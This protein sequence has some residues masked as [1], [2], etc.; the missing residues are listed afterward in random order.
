MITLPDYLQGRDVAPEYCQEYNAGVESNAVDLLMRVNGLMAEFGESRKVNSGWRPPS[1]N[2]TVLGAAK[3][4]RHM[5]GEAIDLD[6][7]YGDLDEWLMS[8]N[9]EEALRQLKLWHEHPASTKGWAHLQSRPP[10]SGNLHF[11]P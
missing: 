7:D 1:Y 11:Y 6:D 9:G 2:C 4:S 8:Q 5:T 10:R 3:T